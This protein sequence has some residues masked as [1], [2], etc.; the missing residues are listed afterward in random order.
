MK[1]QGIRQFINPQG[2]IAGYDVKLT[3]VYSQPLDHRGRQFIDN[4][5]ILVVLA[6]G[7]A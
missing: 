3:N 4:T 2:N 1:G 5:G 7:L 6:V